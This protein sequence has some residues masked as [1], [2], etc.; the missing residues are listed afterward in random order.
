MDVHIG[1]VNSTVHATDAEALLSPQI[2]ER[3]VKVVL[4]RM[5]EEH[6]HEQR[7]LAERR[8]RPNVLTEYGQ[9]WS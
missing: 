1:E 7:V 4:E 2:L 6:A 3:I 5:R 8:L 9:D